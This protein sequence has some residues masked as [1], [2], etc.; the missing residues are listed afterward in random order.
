MLLEKH[1]DKDKY[2]LRCHTVE[3]VSGSKE[4]LSPVIRLQDCLLRHAAHDRGIGYGTDVG[5]AWVG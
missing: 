2:Y 3:T 4:E 5:V 1:E